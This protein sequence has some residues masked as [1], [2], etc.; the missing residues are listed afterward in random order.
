M[1]K[2][3]Q[4][5]RTI[6]GDLGEEPLA[7]AWDFYDLNGYTIDDPAQLLQEHMSTLSVQR[8][9][10][11]NGWFSS[12][13][14]QLHNKATLRHHPEGSVEVD[15]LIDLRGQV[16]SKEDRAFWER[17]LDALQ[18]ALLEQGPL[19]SLVGPEQERAQARRAKSISSGWKLALG[20]S[21][22]ILVLAM[23][24]KALLSPI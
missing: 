2:T 1:A 5:T 14:T 20:A 6:E 7:V 22:V 16:F 13:M 10:P 17:E 9:K 18:E 23:F 24:L 12:D 4:M 8:G 19:R 11:G 21:I 15:Y 3:H